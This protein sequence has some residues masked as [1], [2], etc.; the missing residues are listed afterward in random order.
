M[1][2][3]QPDPRA[4]TDAEALLASAPITAP[5]AA[6]VEE[7]LYELHVHQLELE[8][9]NEG[10]RKSMVALEESRDRFI[11]FYDRSPVGYVTITDT[12]LI[13]DINLPGAALLGVDRGK[14]LWL[15]FSQFVAPESRDRWYS[16][17]SSVLKQDG[18][19]TC[20]LA[21]LRKNGLQHFVQLDSMR[22]TREG[23]P[24]TVRAVLAD[25]TERWQAE[26][27]LQK[28]EDR[29]RQLVETAGEGI[30][31]AQ[32]PLLK[33]VNPMVTEITGYSEEELVSRPFM[34][35]IHQDYRSLMAANY[36]KR[37]NGEAVTQ[38]Y[39]IKIL[40]REAGEKWIEMSGARIEWEGRPATLNFVTDITERKEAEAEIMRSNAEL[41]Q[42]AY[43][44]SHD[45]RQPLR[46]ISSY[47]LL[48]EAAFADQLD[49]EKRDYFNFAIDGAKRLDQML[50]GLLDYSRIGRGG[51]PLAWIESRALLDEAL[52]FLGPE[53]AKAQA[54]V[55][56]QGEWPKI[57]V[58]QDEMLR[59]M[60]NLIGN[61][62]KF[63]VA[64]R[65][66]QITVASETTRH[67]WR[68]S[69][70]D[71]GIGILPDQIGRL[72]QMF[73]RLQSRSDYEGTGVG[74]AMC[75]KI[76]EHHGGR[77][78][79]ESEGADKGCRFFFELPQETAE[80]TVTG[81]Y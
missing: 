56:I 7:L 32:G 30:L 1:R 34:E 17:F 43:A 71:N 16:H 22:L 75:R 66:P 58:S 9:Q 79:A 38:R 67:E 12:G 15:R 14:L 4:R 70:T 52:L 76:A 6:P 23:Q 73:Q 46:M 20:E 78:W 42:F 80:I 28:S 2:R 39:P 50:V 49:G 72:F 81:A 63:R 21:L 33:Y 53:I 27:L 19:L 10:I 65:T 62:L 29:Y 69:V 31:V 36:Q 13:A 5:P 77:I 18:T 24:P 54:D 64:G 74:L 40:T 26:I 35:F 47:M 68:M 41:E 25:I 3:R 8:M 48:L 57:C 60:Q 61:A 55:C 44:I 11:D 37:L 51:E 45:M 59:L